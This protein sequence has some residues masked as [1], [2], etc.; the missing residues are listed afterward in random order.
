M[1]HIQGR[2]LN[3]ILYKNNPGLIPFEKGT[4]KRHLRSAWGKR[5]DIKIVGSRSFIKLSVSA[6]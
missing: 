4:R 6:T 1:G 5:G 3:L 2:T